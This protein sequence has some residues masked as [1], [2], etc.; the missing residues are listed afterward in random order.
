[1]LPTTEKLPSKE[2]LA[3]TT[4]E[5]KYN[6][7]CKHTIKRINIIILRSVSSHSGI[8]KPAALILVEIVTTII[9]NQ[10]IQ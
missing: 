5:A 8:L 6:G 2:H 3:T 7:E 10:S 1:M 4:D 9:A